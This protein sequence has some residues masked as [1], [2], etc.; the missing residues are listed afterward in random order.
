MSTLGRLSRTPLPTLMTVF[1]IGIAL[2]LPGAL[3][4]LTRNLERLGDGWERTAAISLFLKAEV[5]VEKADALVRRLTG[6]PELESINLISPEQALEV[7]VDLHVQG[8]VQMVP[9]TQR[10][11]LIRP[12]PLPR[13]GRHR[14]PCRL[15][16]G[17]RSS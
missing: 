10:L 1:M 7:V 13:R 2:A 4:V 9:L 16:T 5:D 15:A 17:R 12:C 8:I 6:R 14:A 3:Y 11:D